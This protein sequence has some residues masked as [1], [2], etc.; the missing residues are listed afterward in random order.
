[1]KSIFCTA[2]FLALV[3]GLLFSLPLPA[4][5][6]V[7]Q[8]S[9]QA[10]QKIA[11]LGDSI[12]QFGGDH[13]FGYL[14]LVESAFKQQNRPIVV[15]EAGVSGNTS[16]DM[17][18]RLKR[19]VLDQKPDWMTLSCGVNDVW[20]GAQGVALDQYKINITSIVDQVTAAGI[21]V[22][23][24]TST[25]IGEDQPNPNNQKLIAYNDFLRQLAK[26]RNLPLADLNAEMQAE[27]AQ[28]HQELKVPNSGNLLTIDG[29]HMNGPGNE[30]MAAGILQAFGFTDAQLA[31]ARDMWLDLPGA[32][33]LKPV[34]SV[35]VR[36]YLHLRDLAAS[37]GLGVDEMLNQA[38]AK[39]M[40]TMLASPAPAT[41]MK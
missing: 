3:A 9:P 1:M 17:L 13:P 30:M 8:N 26:E 21:K 25:M 40:Q 28:A 23:V 11:F 27:I 38:L 6:A 39:D 5:T 24:L 34:F 37:Q 14:H 2:P 32:V 20:H 41:A 15:I 36:Q 7:P 33:D 12:T 35:S 4:Q 10:G 19:D 31:Q 18:A 16:Q 29:V 22:M